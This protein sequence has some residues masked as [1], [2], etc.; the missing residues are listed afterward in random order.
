MNHS[1][2]SEESMQRMEA[3][4]PELAGSALKLAYLQALTTNGKVIEARHGQLVE[5]T[6]EGGVRVI[7]NIAK[8]IPVRVGEKRVR[9]SKA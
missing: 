2:M 5:T 3:R 6:A 4:I 7:R 9:A 1:R 8:P